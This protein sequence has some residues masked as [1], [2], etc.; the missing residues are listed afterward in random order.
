MNKLM[1]WMV[2][3]LI[4][5]V[6]AQAVCVKPVDGLRVTYDTTFCPGSYE[7][8]RG[9]RIMHSNL[10]V[11]C[12]NTTLLGS[13]I[14][15]GF[16]LINANNVSIL[17]CSV[18]Q[19]QS[20]VYLSASNQN[21]FSSLHF[22][23]NSY[24]ATLVK[25]YENS[26]SNIGGQNQLYVNGGA[27]NV[28]DF[29]KP[30]I[31]TFCKVNACNEKD[32]IYSCI[33][34]DSYCGK[35]CGHD[36]DNDCPYV[37][38]LTVY[39]DHEE[40]TVRYSGDLPD[41]IL[42]EYGI[43]Q[44]EIDAAAEHVSYV[45]TKISE[46][47]QT[48]YEI[49]I[50]AKKDAAGVAILEIV[51]AGEQGKAYFLP[52]FSNSDGNGLIQIE[53]L[54]ANE[55]RVYSYSMNGAPLTDP[56]TVLFMQ[57]YNTLWQAGKNDNVISILLWLTLSTLGVHALLV[58]YMRKRIHDGERFVT[59]QVHK[60]YSYHE[61]EYLLLKNGWSSHAV[62]QALML[63]KEDNVIKS[64]KK[65]MDYVKRILPYVVVFLG[66]TMLQVPQLS[67]GLLR[68]LLFVVFICLFAW[69][70]QMVYH[71]LAYA[72]ARLENNKK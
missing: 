54:K 15:Y 37:A 72:M 61:A 23:N 25:S 30:V 3:L 22:A 11:T 58:V 13:Y 6:S 33:N 28:F 53:E 47:N 44:A 24:A 29:D 1:G 16:Q 40:Q 59:K 67:F 52:P 57:L 35:G 71:A 31:G 26:F 17:G 2:V 14:D 27:F 66:V 42:E 19:F 50:V 46:L 62:A 48:H 34:G 10:V 60:G 7:L 12:E 5:A 43:S 41:A 64:F 51:P 70:C 45:K 68:G 4:L 9:I 69:T 20:G 39:V 32:H 63:A 55:E 21:S 65:L 49:T 56:I 18:M 36:L 38:D 8:E